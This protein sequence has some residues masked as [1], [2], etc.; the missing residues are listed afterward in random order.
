MKSAVKPAAKPRRHARKV[1]ERSQ[2]MPRRRLAPNADRVRV[3]ES[4][5]REP[6]VVEAAAKLGG[7]VAKRLLRCPP[8][9]IAENREHAGAGVLG[10]HVDGIRTQCREGDLRGAEPGTAID[11]ESARLEQLREHL[12]TG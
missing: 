12:R 1:G 2:T 5:W 3:L 6:C 8:R 9:R 10:V 11:A 7:D 4:E